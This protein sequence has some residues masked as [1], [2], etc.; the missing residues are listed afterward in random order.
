MY[1][2]V[3]CRNLSG[4]STKHAK[5]NVVDACCMFL[6]G[7]ADI[8]LRFLQ[9]TCT[10]H[11]GNG[12]IIHGGACQRHRR[13]MYELWGHN[14]L[15]CTQIF[16][17]VLLI[18]SESWTEDKPPFCTIIRSLV[19]FHVWPDM[20]TLLYWFPLVCSQVILYRLF[21]T[22]WFLRAQ[23]DSSVLLLG[24]LMNSCLK[25]PSLHPEA[26]TDVSQHA[27]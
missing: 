4:I 11:F 19:W 1:L 20:T 25:Q 23:A 26:R 21:N 2:W 10:Q 14:T 16:L 7:R 3:C 15:W 13:L 17:L 8:H 9:Q 22:Y 6:D 18:R 27:C 24:E 5:F 12:W